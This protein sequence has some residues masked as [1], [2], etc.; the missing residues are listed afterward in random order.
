M[1]AAWR[2]LS[3]SCGAGT[4]GLRKVPVGSHLLTFREVLRFLMLPKSPL[5]SK[6]FGTFGTFKLALRL[7]G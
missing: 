4:F 3:S 6:D 5:F 1:Y 7:G 2:G